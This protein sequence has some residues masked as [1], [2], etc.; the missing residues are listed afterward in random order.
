MNIQISETKK[1]CISE[2]RRDGAANTTQ[3]TFRAGVNNKE[4]EAD[5][6]FTQLQ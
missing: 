3:Q 6:Q 4:Q 1:G 2:L 5:G